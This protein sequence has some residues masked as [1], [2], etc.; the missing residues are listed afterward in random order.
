MLTIEQLRAMP[1]HNRRGYL[2]IEH[3]QIAADERNA[4]DSQCE[5]EHLERKAR[6]LRD[7]VGRMSARARAGRAYFATLTAAGL[8]PLPA[9]TEDR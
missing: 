5:A 4:I 6:A 7:D 3:N 1:A 2:T 9:P 8:W